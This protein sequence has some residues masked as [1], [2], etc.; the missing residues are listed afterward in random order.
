MR[1]RRGLAR[2]AFAASLGLAGLAHFLSPRVFVDHIPRH[3]PARLELVYASGALEL[4]LAAAVG[5][6]PTR[7]RRRAGLASAAYLVLVFPA[8][9][10]VALAGVPV[11]PAPWLAW[12]RLPLQ[13]L[14]VWW[15]LRSTTST[16]VR[17]RPR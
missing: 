6:L 16:D 7:H 17:A 8:N 1:W 3:V 12:A 10:Y 15:V 11:Y 4:A 14:L 2:L 5:F 13:P 9:L